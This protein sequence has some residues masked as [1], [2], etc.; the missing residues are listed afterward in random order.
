MTRDL[1][2]PEFELSSAGEP[3]STDRWQRDLERLVDGELPEETRRGVLRR[4]D[5]VP[6]GWRQLA[7]AFLTDQELR[8]AAGTLL[9]P[10]AANGSPVEPCAPRATE[11]SWARTAGPWLAMAASLGLAFYLGRLVDEPRQPPAP[12]GPTHTAASAPA[13][14][15]TVADDRGAPGVEETWAAG[16]PAPVDRVRLVVAGADS[17]EP[18]TFD[19]PVYEPIDAP[20]A[21]GRD[22]AGPLPESVRRALEGLG[23]RVEVNRQWV[24]VQLRDGRQG[25]VPIDRVEVI[26]VSLE[27]FQ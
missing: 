22:D 25:V 19:V 27:S 21:W 5:R 23:H 20:L 15:A 24:P 17:D 11:R 14:G 16:R 8:R 7:E 12:R 6:D 1:P 26:P 13:R 18:T 4:L 10:A 2:H 3:S 9:A